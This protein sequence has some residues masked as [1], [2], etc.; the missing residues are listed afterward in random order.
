MRIPLLLPL[1]LL[2]CLTMACTASSARQSPDTNNPSLPLLHFQKTPCL[3]TCPAYNAMIYEDG[4]ITFSAV[5]RA[6]AQDTLYFNLTS[7]ELQQLQQ[8]LEALHFEQLQNAYL[9]QWSDMP[10]TYITFYEAGK[11]AK[12][13]K[14]QEGGPE[15]LLQ[16]QEWLHQL[17]WQRAEEKSR[18]TH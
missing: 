6:V 2:L 18:P 8:Q 4:S 5:K 3:G 1:F 15:N 11:E 14:H 17:V 7:Q 10:A 9:S 16:V 12:R 13:V